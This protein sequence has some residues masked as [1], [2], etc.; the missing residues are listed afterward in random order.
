MSEVISVKE[1]INDT[2]DTVRAR[3]HLL[4]WAKHP[5]EVLKGIV[6]RYTAAVAINFTDWMG[7]TLPWVRHELA[8]YALADN[9]RCETVEN[10]ADMLLD[11]A[12]YCDATPDD[13]SYRF[14]NR[15]VQEIRRLL[16]NPLMAGVV[17]LTVMTLL[18]AISQEFIPIL[19]KIAIR[20]GASNS[21]LQYTQ[22]HGMADVAHADNFTKALK[23]ELTMGYGIEANHDIRE[24]KLAV[25]RLL[26]SIFISSP[27]AVR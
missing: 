15:Q 18:E 10:H 17:G 8:R 12:C 26:N 22:V 4:D 13:D 9:L 2:R 24:A 14:T 19:E 21:Q 16:S 5:D 25:E 3:L 6:R 27:H 20:L 7:K 23:A 11:F 1:L